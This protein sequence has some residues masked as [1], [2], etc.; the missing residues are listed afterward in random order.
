MDVLNTQEVQMLRYYHEHFVAFAKRLDYVDKAQTDFEIL[1]EEYNQM[2]FFGIGSALVNAP[3]F[4]ADTEQVPDMDQL[5][6]K[7]GESADDK[8]KE[9]MCDMLKNDLLIEKVLHIAR[10]HLPKLQG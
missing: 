8:T 7:E 4:L 3:M 1:V 5:E 6:T 9:W 10:V 2:R